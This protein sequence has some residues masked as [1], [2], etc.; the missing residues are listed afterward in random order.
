[1]ETQRVCLCVLCV[2]NVFVNI[3][4]MCVCLDW[5]K[6]NDSPNYRDFFYLQF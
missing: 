4:N 6:K 3:L 2:L 1:M 5:E